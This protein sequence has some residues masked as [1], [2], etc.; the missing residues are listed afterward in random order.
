MRGREIKRELQVN[1]SE[2]L[3]AAPAKR[4]AESVEHLGSPRL[5]RVDHQ[6]ELLAGLELVHRL[7]DERMARQR[8]LE[9]GEDFQGFVGISLSRE[10]ASVRL[11]HAQ[12]RRVE[13]IGVLEMLSCLLPLTGKVEDERGMQLLEDRVPIR[14]G[15]LVD[16]IGCLLRLGWICHRPGRQQGRSKVGDWSTNRLGKL[17]ARVRILHLL[18]S[19]SD[20]DVP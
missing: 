12:R 13:L 3:P 19:V 7:D 4:G 2:I 17:L 6:W 15:E 11:D 14:A 20:E 8:F 10:K 9:R 18:D 5:R 1:E 16:G